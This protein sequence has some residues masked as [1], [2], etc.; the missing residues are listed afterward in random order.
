LRDT[1]LQKNSHQ[2]AKGTL[3]LTI[4]Q[5]VLLGSGYIIHFGL[6]RMV[7]V[8]QYGRFGIIL[9]IL[10]I[11][12]YFVIKGVPDAVAKFV[13]EGR[14]VESIKKKGMKIQLYLSLILYI[15]LFIT[16]PLIAQIL[17]DESLTRYIWLGS[18]LIIGR[19][20]LSIYN[21]ILNGM[22]KYSKSSKVLI[23]YHILRI[24]FVFTL[25]LL[26]FEI[27]G[28]IMGYIIALFIATLFAYKYSKIKLSGGEISTKDLLLFSYPMVIF[29]FS[30][31]LIMNLSLFFVANITNNPCDVAYFTAAS[32]IAGISYTIFLALSF[33]IYPS[34]SKSIKHGAVEQTKSYINYFSRYSFMIL[35]PISVIVY[36]TSGDIITLFYPGEFIAG[37]GALGILIFGISFISIFVIFASIINTAGDSKPSMMVGLS[38]I[39]ISV[40][41]N[42]ILINKYGMVGGAMATT[43]TGFV[44]MVTAGIIAKKLFKTLIPFSSLIK[45]C[46]A[47]GIIFVILNFFQVSGIMILLVDASVFIGYFG[48]LYLFG[49]FK[50]EDFDI[51]KGSLNIKNKT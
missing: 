35:L 2:T 17:N 48:I 37:S 13:A 38:L 24:I 5:V 10:L 25:V 8:E 51:I 9:S 18:L 36:K 50:K 22:K 1:G 14:D 44:G 46:S 19:A 3:Y 7:S 28:A 30:Y 41:T 16:A 26:G 43:I 42:F 49:E 12:Q 34:I 15:I 27:F 20:F 4:A 31:I 47:A 45:I 40:V 23:I 21:G 29:T 39:P 33:T 32:T 11:V 6:A